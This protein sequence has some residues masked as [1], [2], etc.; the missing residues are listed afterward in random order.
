MIQLSGKACSSDALKQQLKLW[1]AQGELS[2][3]DRHFALQMAELHNDDSP[4]MLLM[5]VLVSRQLSRQHPCLDLSAL[6]LAN[7]LGTRQAQLSIQADYAA[8]LNAIAAL[9]AVGTPNDNKP[10]ILEGKRLYLKRYQGFESRVAARLNLMAARELDTHPHTAALLEALFPAGHDTI[11]WQ[12]IAVATAAGKQLTVITGGPGTGKTTT[13]TKLLLLLSLSSSLNIRMVAPTGKAAAR[14]SES[15]KASKQRLAHELTSPLISPVAIESLPEDAS[16]LHRLLGYQ[17]GNHKF[18]H[19]RDN[20]LDVDLLLVD[21]ASMVDLPMMDRLL[22]ALPGHARLILLGDQDQLASVEAGAVLAD[23]CEGARHGYRY[24]AAQTERIAALT[25]TRLSPSTSTPGLGDNLCRLFHSHR[26]AEDAGIGQLAMAVNQGDKARVAFVW[27]Q[28]YPE[29]C[30]IP[31]DNSDGLTALVQLAKTAYSDYLQAMKQQ[32]EPKIIL[33]KY[34]DFRVLCAMKTG[35]Y[36]VEGINRAVTAALAKAGLIQP[37]QEF[38]A[39]R[40]VM[41][42]SNDYSLGL[43]NG[44]IGILLPVEGDNQRLMAHFIQ[45]D[46]QV[47]K[48]LPA[49]LPGHD[50]CYAMTVHKSQ[51]S[52]FASVALSLPPTPSPSQQ[53]LIGRELIYTAITRAKAKFTCLGT[54]ALFDAATERRTERASGLAERLWHEY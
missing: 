12:K 15:I 52:E 34:N 33:Q 16:T 22:D 27:Q 53:S 7:P 36:G 14:L 26:F 39:G 45:S 54:Q 43:F 31:G 40:P 48:V 32:A 17:P 44:D 50:T 11:D 37:T 10:L 49:R 47:L 19:H 8:L 51:G 38:Y 35:E 13:V 41:I 24:S 42:Q 2:S 28:A 30:W 4:L 29:L 9:D 1:Q 5:C 6:V 46:G 21:E 3:L 25:G 18:R 20:P 23:I